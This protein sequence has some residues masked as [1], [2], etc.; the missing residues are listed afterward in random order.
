MKGL[1]I[2]LGG[3]ATGVVAG[4][5]LAPEKGSVTR[6]RVR[7]CLRRKGILPSNEIDLIIEELTSDPEASFDEAQRPAENT[8]EK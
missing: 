2:F 8:D 3:L 5:L 1:S 7:E 6:E 4:L